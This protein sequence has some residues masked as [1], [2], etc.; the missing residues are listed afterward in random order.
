VFNWWRVLHHSEEALSDETLEL[1]LFLLDTVLFPG[2]ALPLHVFEERYLWMVNECLEGD[3]QFGVVMATPAEG[4]STT[5]QRVGT[6]ALITQVERHEDGRMDILTAGLERFRV[7][8]L[9]RTEPYV[10]G[11]I[12]PFP[13]EDCKSPELVRLV[14]TASTLFVQYLRLAG[15]VLGT[16][17]RVESA[18]RDA[19][20]LAYMMAI[21]LQVSNDEKQ[22]LL[23]ISS[24]PTLLWKESSILSR[25]RIL[26]QRMSEAQDDN[27]GYV[28]GVMSNLS[29][30]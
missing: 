1:P 10:V 20:T 14:K 24:L 4:E 30:N 21:A 15:E 6:S 5:A 12:E 16:V 28:R 22:Q 27:K 8:D 26:L 17:I 9:L 23:N 11:R 25:E 13:L 2:M 29:L 19:S 3:R 7:L 18:P